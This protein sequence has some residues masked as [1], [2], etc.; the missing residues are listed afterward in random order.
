MN[1]GGELQ[2]TAIGVQNDYMIG[3]PQ[4]SFYKVVYNRHTNFSMVNI[5]LNSSE[6]EGPITKGSEVLIDVPRNGDL[7]SKCN[8]EMG[9]NFIINDFKFNA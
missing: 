5:K 1:S 7:L 2:L 4:I 8:L 9:V 6:R 3:N